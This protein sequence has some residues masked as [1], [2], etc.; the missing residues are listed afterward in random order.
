MRQLR[1]LG[2]QNERPSV[3]CPSPVP[4]SCGRW[5]DPA[6]PEGVMSED[7]SGER[8]ARIQELYEKLSSLPVEER[9]RILDV[10]CES[11]QELREELE[12]LLSRSDHADAEFKRLEEEVIQSPLKEAREDPSGF[13]K[14]LEENAPPESL[15]KPSDYIG[16]YK[17]LKSIGEGGFGTVWEAE[18]EKPVRRRV[19]LRPAWTGQRR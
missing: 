8:L 6:L 16:N 4:G 10:A 9:A 17:L 5:K 13:G 14:W 18:Q 12:S 11:D 15:E 19:A 1:R 3:A 2:W 7:S